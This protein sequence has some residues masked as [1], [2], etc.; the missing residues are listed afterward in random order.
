MVVVDE[1]GAPN[2]PALSPDKRTLLIAESGAFRLSVLN[3]EVDGSLTAGR[4]F[5]AVP[6][7]PGGPGFAPPDGICLDSE[8]RLGSRIQ[9]AVGSCDS[10]GEASSPTPWTLPPRLPRHAFSGV[11]TDEP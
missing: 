3:V 6:S 1:L 10:Y 7:A 5:A 2:W 8:G 9:S 11:L 4:E